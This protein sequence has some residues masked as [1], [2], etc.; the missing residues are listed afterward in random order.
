MIDKRVIKN[1]VF[2]YIRMFFLIIISLLT[3]RILLNYLGIVD[4]GIYSLVWGII[5][6]LGFL[7]NSIT[8]SVQRFLNISLAENNILETQKIY[9]VSL[10]SFVFLGALVSLFFIAIKGVVFNNFLNIPLNKLDISLKIYNFMVAVFFIN[11][12]SLS[13]QSCLISTERFSFF[14]FITVFE[15]LLKLIGVYL[16]L[17]LNERLYYYSVFLLIVSFFV[18]VILLIYC[19]RRIS[20]CNFVLVKES[21]YY[22]KILSFISWNMVGSGG[23]VLSNQGLPMVFNMFYGV[24]INASLSIASQMTAL[25]GVFVSNFQKAFSPYLMKEYVND[26]N[27]A[28]KIFILSKLSLI[29]YSFSAFLLIF[30]PEDILKLWLGNVPQ[31]V[32]QIVKISSFIVL[33]EVLAGPLWMVIQAQGDIK[34]YQISVFVIMILSIPFA[35]LLLYLKFNIYVVWNM[36]LLLNIILLILRVFFVDSILGNRFLTQYFKKVLIPVLFFISISM[37]ILFIISLLNF[38]FLILGFLIKILLSVIILF[39]LSYM[40]LLDKTQKQSIM[41]FSKH[42]LLGVKK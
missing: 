41:Q 8:N 1:A 5:L 33:C 11:F 12:I 15:A 20:F 32:D 24:V 27:V 35:Y 21:S 17:F 18:M 39:M 36:L 42:K 40:I 31:Y 4:F 23:V 34:R 26:T 25:I 30:Y 28:N 37:G 7:N 16:L 2:L 19:K 14:S 38:N 6:L 13:F 9:S 10:I 3:T 22:K 29:F